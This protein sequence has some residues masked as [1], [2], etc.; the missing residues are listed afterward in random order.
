[1]IANNYYG[2]LTTAVTHVTFLPTTPAYITSQPTNKLLVMLAP[3]REQRLRSVRM[4]LRLIT[5]NGYMPAPTTSCTCLSSLSDTLTVPGPTAV[6]DGGDITAMVSNGYGSPVN[7]ATATFT[8]IVPAANSYAALVTSLSPWGYWRL[9]GVTLN[10]I[11]WS[12]TIGM[13]ITGLSWIPPFRHIGAA[14]A[15]YIGFPV[16]HLGLTVKIM[17]V[18]MHAEST[19]P[20]FRVGPTR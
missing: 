9:G 19:C 3:R 18:R 6:A 14:A 17:M 8:V 7:S 11:L 1:M 5:I 13:A 12:T 16:P 2:S 10:G 20:S 4:A 15:P